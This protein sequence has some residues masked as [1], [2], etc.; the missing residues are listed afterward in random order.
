MSSSIDSHFKHLYA[1]HL[2]H[3]ALK[4]YRPKTVEAYSR[5]I[6]RIA[7]YFNEAITELS[8]EQLL[9]YFTD[10]LKTHSWSAIKLDLYG[11]KFFYKHVLNKPWTFVDLVKPPSAKVLPD[12]LTIK[13]ASDL[14][15][16]THKL[17]YRVL[18]F[19]LYSMGL[20]LSEGIHLK[21]GDVDADRMRV[22]IRDAKGNKDRFVPLPVATLDVLRAF[23]AVHR[24]PVWLFPNRKGGLKGSTTANTPLHLGGAQACMHQV[25][26]DSGLKKRFPSI[27]Y[28]IAMPRICWRPGWICWRSS[29]ISAIA[30]S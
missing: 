23:W 13:Q 27:R 3:L 30:A 20:R 5:A 25:V 19:T 4:G 26:Q 12:V 15:M 6:R 7:A 16:A 14:F 18:F 17:S 29:A 8:E 1:L 11:L 10:L 24:N 21:V 9:D 2:K 22:H 28:A